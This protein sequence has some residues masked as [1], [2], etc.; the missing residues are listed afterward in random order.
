MLFLSSRREK[1]VSNYKFLKICAWK[2]TEFTFWYIFFLVSSVIRLIRCQLDI[3]RDVSWSKGFFIFLEPKSQLFGNILQNN[4]FPTPKTSKQVS[5]ND[6][7]NMMRMMIMIMI[8][9]IKMKMILLISLI[10][11]YRFWFIAN[12]L[13]TSRRRRWQAKDNNLSKAFW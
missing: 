6:N 7:V 5:D 1:Q 13:C 10:Y 12:M 11:F 2:L 3:L 9:I 8:I 4:R